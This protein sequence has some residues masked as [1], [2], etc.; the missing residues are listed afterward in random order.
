MHYGQHGEGA[1]AVESSDERSGGKC[2]TSPVSTS[3]VRGRP[4]RPTRSVASASCCCLGHL[5]ERLDE[6]AHHRL[7]LELC[8]GDP[9]DEVLGAWLA[10]ES[11]RD[12][13]LTDA[14]AAAV[15]IDKAIAGCAADDLEEI[16]SPAAPSPGETRSW[17]TTTPAPPAPRPRGSTCV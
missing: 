9:H 14:K 15:L 16:R 6:Q 2:Y 13:F 7:L 3:P 12:L 4:L 1:T 5:T 8:I 17:P 10:K 11:V